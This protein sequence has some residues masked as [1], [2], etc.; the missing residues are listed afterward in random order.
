MSENPTQPTLKTIL[1]AINAIGVELHELRVEMNARFERLEAEMSERFDD[2]DGRMEVLAGDV[3]KVR[4]R[5][6]RISLIETG[7]TEPTATKPE[8]KRA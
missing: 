8:N 1:E 7:E 4:A 2:L 6:G 5:V 3:V